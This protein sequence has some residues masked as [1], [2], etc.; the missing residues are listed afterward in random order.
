MGQNG[1]RMLPRDV[2][3]ILSCH[4]S[5]IAK[6]SSIWRSLDLK[7]KIEPISESNVSQSSDSFK[8]SN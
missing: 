1:E 5:G 8:E 6:S 2:V 3:G 7:N 4:K